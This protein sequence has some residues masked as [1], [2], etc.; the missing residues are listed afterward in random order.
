MKQFHEELQSG[1]FVVTRDK[2]RVVCPP[3]CLTEFLSTTLE[4]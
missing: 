2:I 4:S 1:W 3:E